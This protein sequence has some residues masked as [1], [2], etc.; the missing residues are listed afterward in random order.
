[1]TTFTDSTGKKRQGIEVACATCGQLF[2]SRS[3]Q[4]RKFCSLEC[5]SAAAK[6]EVKLSCASCGDEFV[7]TPS[8]L[9]CSRSGI[10]F[11]SRKCKDDA[12]RL[13]EIEAILPS[14]YGTSSCRNSEFYRKVYK[15]HYG[16]LRC[17]RC[18]YDEFECGI[19]IH[20][21]DGCYTN[22]EK[23]NLFALCAPCHRALHNKL[24][25]FGEIGITVALQATFTSSS[26]VGST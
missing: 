12:Q 16:D 9:K 1:M 25:G 6:T 8:K 2:Q 21:L 11:C 13:G 23:E 5:R 24:W 18:G 20:H 22:N 3:D 26:L 14:H 15:S 4:V 7:R 17:G 19:D 10:Y